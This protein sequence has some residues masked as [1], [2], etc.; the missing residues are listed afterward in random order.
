MSSSRQKHLTRSLSPAVKYF[1]LLAVMLSIYSSS[2][3]QYSVTMHLRDSPAGHSADSIFMAGNHNQ[4]NPADSNNRFGTGGGRDYLVLKNVPAGRYE[5][6]FTRGSWQNVETGPGGEDAGNRQ[7][8]I[9]SDTVIEVSILGWKDDFAAPVKQRT[10]SSNVQVLD[11]A[12]DLP[13]LGRARRLWIYL[14]AGYNK[15]KKRYP[16]M[17]M[18]DG[19]NLF[20]ESTAAF[21]EWGV[22]ECLDSLSR[23]KT[24]NKRECIVIGIDNGP[25]RMN[26]Y[27]PYEFGQAGKG[28][29]KEYVDFLANTLKPYIDKRYRTLTS[30]QNTIIAGSSMGGLI[31]YY[32]MLKY[33]EVF[34]KG[35]IFSPAFWTADSIK[36]LTGAAG[37][38]L[39]GNL[40]FYMGG[41]EGDSS[42]DDMQEITALL[43]EHSP[44]LIYEVIDPQA[45][46][47]EQAWRKWFPEFV[48]WALADGFNKILK[49]ED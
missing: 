17:Y 41:Q 18:H 35:G 32:A 3:S 2:F 9:T 5:F 20:D 26:E 31:S 12:F 45:A 37:N 21:G 4:W 25:R 34:G 13:Q 38:K 48:T 42:I 30:K 36:V 28:E 19:Q 40:F 22:D 16:V 47:N 11:S 24:K 33:P 39:T 43:G 14:P 1:C 44:A 6:K 10:L 8:F 46:H 49:V 23:L 7:L 29:G 15:R 27:N